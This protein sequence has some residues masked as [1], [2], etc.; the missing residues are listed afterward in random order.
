M[1]HVMIPLMMSAV[2]ISDELSAAALSRG[3]D[4]PDG[5][6]CLRQIKF[7]APDYLAM[8]YYLLLTVCAVAL[9]ASGA[10]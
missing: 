9:K 8:G 5:H 7:E 2:N 3:F 10:F 4:K 1:E 6:T